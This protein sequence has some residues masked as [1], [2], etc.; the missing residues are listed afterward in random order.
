MR[1]S[2]KSTKLFLIQAQTVDFITT[3]LT[4]RAK[5][6]DMQGA[7][8]DEALEIVAGTGG[9]PVPKTAQVKHPSSDPFPRVLTSTP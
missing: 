7:I 9:T 4:N 8:S 1:M 6:F 5:A 3:L 2:E